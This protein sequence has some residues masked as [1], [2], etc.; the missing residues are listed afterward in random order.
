MP[1]FDYK[2][3]LA[4]TT[5]QLTA[6]AQPTGSIAQ[7]NGNDSKAPTSPF[8]I[9]WGDGSSTSGFFPSNHTYA[10]ATRNYVITLTS[11][12]KDGSSLVIQVP[13]L[14]AAPTINATV[15]TN[16]I[17]VSFPATLGV[18]Q[19]ALGYSAPNTANWAVITDFGKVGR[20]AWEYILSVAANIAY[21][22]DGSAASFHGQNS[23]PIN[24]V[25]DSSGNYLYTVWFSNPPVIAVPGSSFSASSTSASL[26]LHE[27]G[28]QFDLNSLHFTSTFNVDG[29]ANGIL[30][31]SLASIVH[32]A[33][34]YD[35]LNNSQAYGIPGDFALGLA[36]E[37]LNLF[38]GIKSSYDSYV[39]GGKNYT[40]WGNTIIQPDPTLGTIN[41]LAYKFVEHAEAAGQGFLSP[42]I[43][44]THLLEQFKSGDMSSYSPGADSPAAETF[45]ASLM[46]AALSYAF[47]Q[48]LRTEFRD[49]N[50]PISDSVYGDFLSRA[51][52]AGAI[53]AGGP[54]NDIL[55]AGGG[56]DILTG[57]AGVDMLNGGAG[58][59]SLTGGSGSDAIDGG[60]G[61][62]T[63]YFSGSRAS[64]TLTKTGSTSYT[65][66]GADGA[67]TLTNVELLRF[68][69]Q[70]VQLAPGLPRD[71][72]ADGA[73]DL[74]MRYSDGGLAAW[75]MDGPDL[76]RGGLIGNPGLNWVPKDTA[77]F[78]G[79]GKAD[80]L[81]QNI[82]SSIAIWKVDGTSLAGGNLVG[83]P[84]T[85]WQARLAADFDGNGTADILLQNTDSS[86]V[87]WYVSGTGLAGGV[88]TGI[89]PGPAWKVKGAGDFNGDSK[90]DIILQRDS[91]EIALWTLDNGN[92][93][94]AN[95][96]GSP[97]ESWHVK[98]VADFDGDGKA[99]ILMQ[100]DDSRIAI[101]TMNGPAMT[102]AAVLDQPG[103][104]WQVK[105]AY[106]MNADGKADIV[107][108]RTSG[109]IAVWT[110][111]GLDRIGAA[112]SGNPGS[113]WALVGPTG[114]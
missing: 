105:G 103:P 56:A 98:S 14:F 64:Y 18:Y 96:V 37:T 99:D 54:G 55:L 50:F 65:I 22:M 42:V 39:A 16:L 81:L 95:L 5:S 94:S 100:H 68:S 52:R 111:N 114:G 89:T 9:D 66:S 85:N 57:D 12:E 27:I 76:V 107:L 23:F 38:G 93:V 97:G 44:M 59:D 28:H 24:V 82:D 51:D 112:L 7:L 13:V 67:D 53:F 49:L 47:G 80:I 48:D 62:D 15:P 10:D 63:A 84:G 3:V 34:A 70:A 108:Q 60:A 79:D 102:G 41:T 91:G 110:M 17:S 11:H 31:E 36:S 26:I 58:S 101:W 69:D 33:T 35:L 77:D 1:A 90:A 106:D 46:V 8:S 61:F 45:R 88:V 40:S 2:G 19:G 83:T 92:F 71:F 20:Q 43:R 72:D 4:G 73:A 109:E 74:L 113:A 104:A 32:Y 21:R 75:L 30:T 25:A 78:D 86:V 29:Q 6:N 87:V